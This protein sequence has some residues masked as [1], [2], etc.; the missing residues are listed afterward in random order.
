MTTARQIGEAIKR[1]GQAGVAPCG[2][3][4]NAVAAF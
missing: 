2:I 4:F 1:T 3:V